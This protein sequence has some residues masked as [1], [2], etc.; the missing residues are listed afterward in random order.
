MIHPDHALSPKDGRAEA[1]RISWGLVQIPIRLHIVTEGGSSVPQRSMFT[2]DGNPI[3]KRDYDKVTGEDYT[4]PVI[5]K[6]AV[7]DAWIE[8]SDNEIAAHSTLTK[9]IAEIETFIPLD[10]IG[11]LYAAERVGAWT[12]DTMT[13]G[14]TKIIDPTAAKAVALL[15]RAMEAQDVAALVLVPGKYG[16]KYVALLP[17]GATVYLSFADYVRPIADTAD[18]VEVTKGELAMASQLIDGIGVSEPVLVDA[19]G[20]LLRAYLDG[21]ARG[22]ITTVASAPA[23]VEVDLMA[24]LAASLAATPKKAVAK[25]A[26]AK[27][28]PAAKARRK[29]S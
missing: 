1:V 5:K 8:L 16:P 29:A 20:E 23:P 22:T 15:R 9:G 4:G 10:S 24:A 2:E 28:A 19:A 17:N 25:K 27:K 18:E 6:V 3:G 12:P 14:R 13:V 11:T 26:A 21:K 7:S